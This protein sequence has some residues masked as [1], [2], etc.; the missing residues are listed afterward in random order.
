MIGKLDQRITFQRRTGASDGAGGTVYSWADLTSNPTV[1]ANVLTAR[2]GEATEEGRMNA[3]ALVVFTIRNRQ[4]IDERDRI[5]WGGEMHNIRSVRRDG[6]R[7][8]YLKIEAE[9]G[10]AQ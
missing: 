6:A 4:D 5:S 7:G 1:W 2:L 10:V 3:T 9:R 8:L